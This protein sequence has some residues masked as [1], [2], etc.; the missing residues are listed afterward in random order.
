M[1]CYISLK[2]QRGCSAAAAATASS[3]TCFHAPQSQSR[4]GQMK[5][6]FIP[7]G[8]ELGESQAGGANL[9]DC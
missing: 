1:L 2:E 5:S 6:C 7:L 9:N 4:T 8:T 3:K